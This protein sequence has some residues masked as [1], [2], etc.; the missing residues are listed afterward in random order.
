MHSCVL[1]GN[2]LGISENW[3]NYE[4]N[5]IYIPASDC[6]RW[7]VCMRRWAR[8]LR[9]RWLASWRKWM[10]STLTSAACQRLI[11]LTPA[12]QWAT[13]ANTPAECA[14]FSLC[15]LGRISSPRPSICLVRSSSSWWRR[16]SPWSSPETGSPCLFTAPPKT[17]PW[18][19]CLSRYAQRSVWRSFVA[20]SSTSQTR[21]SLPVPIRAPQRELSRDALT[22]EWETTRFPWPQ[23]SGKRSCLWSVST[24]QVTTLWG[25]SLSPQE[26][27]LQK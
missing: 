1:R 13:A 4:F 24:G 23:A 3:C 22:S 20:L 17:V 27:T 10:S 14:D 16:T 7:K 21:S 9:Q 18:A 5:H 19:K 25:A 2:N 12:T 8:P 15:W 11:G 26:T 6:F